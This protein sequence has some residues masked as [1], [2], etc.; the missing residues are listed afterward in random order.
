MKYDNVILNKAWRTPTVSSSEPLPRY[1]N[2]FRKYREVCGGD[3][4]CTVYNHI[5]NVYYTNRKL[6]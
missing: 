3:K 2:V 5:I 4:F 1:F 6:D